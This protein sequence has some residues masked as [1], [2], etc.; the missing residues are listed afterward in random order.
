MIKLVTYLRVSTVKQGASGLGL[1][2]QRA[3]VQ[4]YAKQLGAEIIAEYLE[5]ESGKRADRPQLDIAI[6]HAKFA[7]AR[8]VVA[9]LDRLARN[10]AFLSALMEAKADFV[11]CDN[12]HATPLTLHILAAVAEDEAR[13]ISDRTKAALQAVKTRGTKLGSQRDGHWEGREH[14]RLAG[15]AKARERSRHVRTKNADE[16]YRFLYSTV[17]QMREDRG[18]TYQQIADTLNSVGHRTARGC[19]WTASAAKRV[20]D[21][22]V[23]KS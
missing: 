11:C 23:S 22:A 17:V 2:A 16:R 6:G 5:V 19:K 8:L 13:R 4:L 10:V 15:L 12:P 7:G 3:A 14:L 21:R 9:K 18:M 1:E 20:Y